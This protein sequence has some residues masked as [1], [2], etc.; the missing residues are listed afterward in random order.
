MLALSSVKGYMLD[1]DKKAVL[2]KSVSLSKMCP[3]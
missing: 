3:S 2:N 1:A